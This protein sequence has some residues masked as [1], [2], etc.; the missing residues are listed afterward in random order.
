MK[1]IQQ[2]SGKVCSNRALGR[3]RRQGF[4]WK[5]SKRW[6][7]TTQ[8][9]IRLLKKK[10]KD[11]ADVNIHTQ[12]RF[13]NT[14]DSDQLSAA[15]PLTHCRGQWADSGSRCPQWS[16]GLCSLW[17]GPPALGSEWTL[18]ETRRS[19]T[20]EGEQRVSER[21][22]QEESVGVPVRSSSLSLK[23]YFMRFHLEIQ[24]KL[25]INPFQSS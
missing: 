19:S 12:K 25:G 16:R 3:S 4:Y 23:K 9:E 5:K 8:A 7:C 10:K 22:R 18:L 17:S 11:H 14:G 24:W 15:S 6:P 13:V 21:E 2:L 1:N 20:C